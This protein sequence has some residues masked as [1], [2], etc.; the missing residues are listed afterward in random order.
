MDG[1]SDNQAMVPLSEL[2]TLS[3][4]EYAD[5]CADLAEH[6]ESGEMNWEQAADLLFGVEPVV[7]Y[8]RWSAS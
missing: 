8:T 5:Y 2:G 1:R 7:T 4:E 3:V 6:V